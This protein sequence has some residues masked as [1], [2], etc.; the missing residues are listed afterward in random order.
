MEI[1]EGKNVTDVL[2][3]VSEGSNEIG[4]VYATDAT[5]VTDKV[6]IIAEAPGRFLEDAGSL[7]GGTYCRHR[8]HLKTIAAAADA[9]LEYLQTD[10]AM[11]VFEDY[12]FTAYEADDTKEATAEDAKEDKTEEDR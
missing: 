6:D 1:N 9:F 7:S 5:S 8:K 4:I 10:E 11:K 3:S 12:G 2:A